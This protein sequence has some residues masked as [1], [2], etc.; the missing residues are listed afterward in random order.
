MIV[1][2]WQV[3]GITTFSRGQYLQPTLGVDWLNIGAFSSSRP[4]V[5]GNISANRSLPDAY[6]NP[7]AFDYPRDASGN[8]IHVEGNAGRNTVEQPGLDNW[9]VG[10]VKNAS[11]GER[12]KL[13]FRCET[14]NTWNHTQFGPANMA[15]TSASFGKITSV[16]VSPRLVQLGMRLSY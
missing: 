14:F 3:T 11:I 8:P 5:V 9:D 13:Q 15:T 16:L 2:G 7:A 6:L 1:G 10:L 12:A 4:N